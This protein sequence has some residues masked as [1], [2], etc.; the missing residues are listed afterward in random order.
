MIEDKES[1]KTPISEI[2]EV[3]LIKQLTQ[4]FQIKNSST[5]QGVGDDAAVI[6]FEKDL[7]VISTET[8]V[9]GIHFDIIYSPLKHLGYKCVISAI[10]DIVAM[11]AQATQIMVSYTISNKYP[12]E[13]L[14][15]MYSGI[16]TACEIY[17][18][19]LVG[20]D[21][22]TA[23]QGLSITITAM[24]RQKENKL[25]Y[26]KGAK[27]N[28]LLVLTGDL[29]ASYMGLLIL[30]RE[31]VTYESNPKFQPDLAP[32]QYLIERQLKPEARKDIIDFFDQNNIQPT[33]M[34]DLSDGLANEVL[35]LSEQ[36]EIGFHIYENKI[37]ID[38]TVISSCEEFDINP[39]IAAL[40]GGGD[41]ELLFTLDQ[42]DHQVVEG[43]PNFSIIG[44]A[45]EKAD[46]PYLVSSGT[47]QLIEITAQG[48]QPN[49]S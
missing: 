12:V 49:H 19:D 22:T 20:G 8:L 31:K 23:P 6:S 9:E 11:N 15:E 45:T 14:E 21:T 32:Y 17:G 18:L 46:K 47:E 30:E 44:F 4:D 10:S 40:N 33:S 28:D 26:R 36:S 1:T 2:G 25:V 42:K 35:H 5:I 43:N 27:N 7:A 39:S 41:Y 38:P 37:P 16:H 13:A 29:G 24:G 3:Q 34:I 48:W